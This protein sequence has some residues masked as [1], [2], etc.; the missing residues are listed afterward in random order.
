MLCE[1]CGKYKATAHIKTFVNGVAIEKHLCDFCASAEGL[2]VN[3]HSSIGSILATMLSDVLETNNSTQKRCNIC[4]MSF[5]DIAKSGKVGCSEC[6][7]TFKS[8]LLPYIKRVH[9]STQHIGKTPF[10]N[11]TQADN[12][13]RLKDELIRLI[14]EENYEQAAVVRDKIRSLEAFGNE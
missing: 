13:K 6:Y 7:N 10:K 4:G 12:I 3:H 1:K 5:N 2:A 11:A 9:G 14:S 8:E